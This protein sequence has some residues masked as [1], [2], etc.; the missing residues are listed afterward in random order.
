M[1]YEQKS[2]E[3]KSIQWVDSESIDNLGI[4]LSNLIC[5]DLSGNRIELVKTYG[6]ESDVTIFSF[7]AEWCPNCH[8]EAKQIN[9]LFLDYKDRG[10]SLILVMDYSSYKKSL[11][12][13]NNCKLDVPFVFGELAEKNEQQKVKT[14]FYKF[15]SALNDERGWGVPFHIILEKDNSDKLGIVMGEFISNDIKTYLGKTLLSEATS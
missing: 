5:R 10:L 7:F 1:L 13:V 11:A 4:I 9:Q 15:R 6:G 3:Y 12:F 8:Y 14:Q 2:H